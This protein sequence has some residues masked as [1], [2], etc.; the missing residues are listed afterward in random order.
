MST[1]TKTT[2]AGREYEI[3]DGR[4]LV[5]HADVWEDEEPFDI[6]IPLRFKA[7]A[8]R[9]I[10]DITTDDAGGM[11]ELLD[12]LIPD[13]KDKVD[14]LDVNDLLE[15]VNVWFDEYKK[16]NGASVGEASGSSA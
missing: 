10:K 2:E 14:E 7:R 4:R 5:W 11:L 3:V 15:L 12:E 6:V 1:E 8:L 13:Q 16:Q 9:P